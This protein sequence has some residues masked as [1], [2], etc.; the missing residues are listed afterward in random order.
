MALSPEEGVPRLL[1]N[2]GGGELPDL[3]RLGISRATDARSRINL[4]DKG[5]T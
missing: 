4:H 3:M 5:A 1:T 2:M